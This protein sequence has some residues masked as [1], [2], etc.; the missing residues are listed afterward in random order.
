MAWAPEKSDKSP[1]DHIFV[2]IPS[3][4]KAPRALLNDSTMVSSSSYYHEEISETG[5]RLSYNVI[6]CEFLLNAFSRS[7][8]VGTGGFVMQECF[9]LA[10]RPSEPSVI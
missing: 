2:S 8:N 6:P 10:L 4:P 9:A 7:S 1:F 5:H 3:C